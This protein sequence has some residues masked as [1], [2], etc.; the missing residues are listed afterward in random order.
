MC[1][2]EWGKL[3][4][5]K[6]LKG[7]NFV[8]GKLVFGWAASRFAKPRKFPKRERIVTF[9][10]VQ[11]VTKKHVLG[12]AKSC[13]WQVFVRRRP[14][15]QG[16]LRTD[17]SKATMFQG[18]DSVLRPAIQSSA[19]NS[20]EE[21]FRRHVSKPVFRKK[22]GEKALNRS[23]VPVLQREDLERTTKE[24]PCFLR[25]VGY[26]WVGICGVWSEKGLLWIAK[27]KGLC[28]RTAFG[29]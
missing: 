24:W 17:V 13:L 20:F 28:K 4:E 26:G 19:G 14:P 18:V 3:S 23:E 22:S 7:F 16:E 5:R 10:I 25:T 6:V 11:K 1:C 29:L 15:K 9:C 12:R 8:S 2:P 27:R 21:A